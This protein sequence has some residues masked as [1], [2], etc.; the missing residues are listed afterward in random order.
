M[1]RAP[2]RLA[3]SI[4]EWLRGLGAGCV[5]AN[6]PCLMDYRSLTKTNKN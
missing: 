5:T 6:L 4:K 3:P 2:A 1:A